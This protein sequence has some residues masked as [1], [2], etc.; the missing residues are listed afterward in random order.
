MPESSLKECVPECGLSAQSSTVA[1]GKVLAINRD[2]NFVIVDIGEDA[3]VKIGDTFRVYRDD[4][5][6]AD[7][8]VIQ[9][10]KNIAAC[11]IKVEMSPI[12]IGD[13]IR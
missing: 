1:G 2:S 11:D 4:K 3:G 7:L 5:S 6:V 13:S 10:R 12:K 9:T 8:E